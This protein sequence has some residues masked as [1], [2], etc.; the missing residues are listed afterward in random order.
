MPLMTRK[1]AIEMSATVRLGFGRASGDTEGGRGKTIA[2]SVIAAASVSAIQNSDEAQCLPMHPA[3]YQ[4]G[5]VID[6]EAEDIWAADGHPE[7]A[8]A[9]ADR[10]RSRLPYARTA[11]GLLL[12]PGRK[13]DI[14]V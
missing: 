11:K 7:T 5:R 2:L 6:V 10:F 8:A 3:T 14:Y 1:L 12:L 13:T 9:M 4:R